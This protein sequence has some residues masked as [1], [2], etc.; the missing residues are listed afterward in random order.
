MEQETHGG[1][2]SSSLFAWRVASSGAPLGSSPAYQTPW[3][4]DSHYYSPDAASDGVNHVVAYSD[5]YS[6]TLSV[7]AATA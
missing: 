1:V 5:F 3:S 4:P 7:V 2:T 6:H